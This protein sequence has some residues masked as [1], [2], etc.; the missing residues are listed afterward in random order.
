MYRNSFSVSSGTL[1][2]VGLFCSFFG[3][4]WFSFL[5]GSLAIILAVLSKGNEKRMCTSAGVGMI[6]GILALII[7]ICMIIFTLY[8]IIY[9][10]EFREQF[11]NT[12][13]HIYEQMYGIP[14][15]ES[16]PGLM[17]QI[18]ISL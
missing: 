18:G 10:P 3:M 8:S 9:I 12:F 6:T 17:E 2:L 14:F 15:Q 11:I 13:Y 16:Y 1:G 7:Q 4:F 5:F